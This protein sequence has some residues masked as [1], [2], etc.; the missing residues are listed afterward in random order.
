MRKLIVLVSLYSSIFATEYKVG[1]EEI[2][3]IE[4]TY[5]NLD[6]QRTMKAK[7]KIKYFFS[8]SA[9][10][11]SFVE[12]PIKRLYSFLINGDIDFKFP[13]NPTWKPILKEG[14]D[15]Y[16]SKPLFETNDVTIS[17][18]GFDKSKI[19][20]IGVIRGYTPIPFL[21]KIQNNEVSV[22]EVNSVNALIGLLTKK[23][24][25][26][27][28]INKEMFMRLKPDKRIFNLK[29]LSPVIRTKYHL[30][31]IKYPELL[32]VFDS[33]LAKEN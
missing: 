10:Q 4:S 19:M 29:D 26:A 25:D 17:L 16:Y 9:Q 3:T 5:F 23:R 27:I 31:T 15:I 1:I 6:Y 14:K 30:S 18:A 8:N 11:V 33:Y 24:V 13:D 7:E 12:L 28:Y 22:S 32:K 2:K 20:K 21:A